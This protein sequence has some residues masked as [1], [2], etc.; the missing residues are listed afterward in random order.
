MPA[1]QAPPR[2]SAAFHRFWAGSLASNL[3]DGVML[4]AL[5]LL[6][7]A[8]TDDPLAVAGLTAARY[9]PWLLFGLVGGALVDRVDRGRAM[10]AANLLRA[11]AVAALAALVALDQAGVGWLYAVMFTVMCCEIVYDLSGRAMLPALAPGAVD[12]ANGRL[13]AS[14]E[15][16]QDFVGAPLA[17]FLFAVAAALPLAVNSGAYLLGAL[18]LMG[19]PS[20]ARR[21]AAQAREAAGRGSLRADIGEGLRFV[22]GDRALRALVVF[23]T[24]VN[25]AAGAQAAV[26][27]LVVR[28][29]LGVPAPLFGVFLAVGAVGALTG[30]LLAAGLAARVGRFAAV[31]GGYLLQ[32]VCAVVVAAATGSPWIGAAAWAVLAGASA[33]AGVLSGGIVQQIVPSGLLGRVMSVRRMLGL[34]MVPVGA[35]LGG[36]LARLD[37]RLPL[38]LGAVVFTLSTL[39]VLRHL[40]RAAARADL[41]ER[42]ARRES[43]DPD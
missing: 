26:L 43:P 17:G 28:D 34:G 41:A 12:R 6:A 3:A 29:H 23:S 35:L 1:D 10:V 2:L 4:T 39:A 8:L 16:A 20:A 27:V 5:P 15:T 11:G 7:V 18:I 24:A 37:L 32:A 9:L 30:A 25:L 13:T 36:L 40:R 19:L 22:Y 21:P 31:T 14:Q 42:R 38:L 33:V